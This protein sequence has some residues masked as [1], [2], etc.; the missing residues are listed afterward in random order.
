[1]P[2]DCK[3]IELDERTA[4]LGRQLFADVRQEQANVE[5]SLLR[6]VSKRDAERM[7]APD[8]EI[9]GSDSAG[10]DGGDGGCD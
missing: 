5:A 3:P 4:R 9:V 10:S 7:Q 1:M 2:T 8:I 6:R